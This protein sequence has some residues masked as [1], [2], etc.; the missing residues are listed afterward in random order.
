MNSTQMADS[1]KILMD[2]RM[3][4]AKTHGIARYVVD[5]VQDLTAIGHE[6]TI[7]ANS[8][9]TPKRIG[10]NLNTIYC[11]TPFAH[12]AES[13][14]LTYKCRGKKFDVFH[15]PSFALPLIL[16]A[17]SVVTIHDLIHLH[18]PAKLAHQ[19]YYK[20]IVKHGLTGCSKIITVS[21]WTK[22]ELEK[23]L[24]VNKE[25]IQVIRNGIRK[26]SV[27][28]TSVPSKPFVLCLASLK[29]HK[30]VQAL[31]AAC[32]KL[33]NEGQDFE[34]VLSL[35]GEELP[36]KWTELKPKIRLIKNISDEEI[37]G[38]LAHCAAIV[39]TSLF[40]GFNY[41]VAEALSLGRF[42]VLSEG[43]A[44]SEFDS[45]NAI[46]FGKPNDINNLALTLRKVFRGEYQRGSDSNI[47]TLRQ[48]TL[49]TA[50]LYNQVF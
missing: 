46:Y 40:E 6:V 44:H 42:A 27:P 7:L 13:L 35:G 26:I 45:P 2:A 20:T 8:I 10:S 4:G 41:P 9:E 43:S 37:N 48:M 24:K 3:V 15:F 50:A 34:L 16:P 28:K 49:S 1:L 21:D 30:N 14:E 18:P 31:L 47:S 17:R 19:M 33:W 12:P 25:K 36:S 11:K 32:R 39:S 29:P 5:L 22:I 38:Y 23:F